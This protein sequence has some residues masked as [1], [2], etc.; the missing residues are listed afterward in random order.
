MRSNRL[1][2]GT[3][4]L[5]L[6]PFLAA[7]VSDR[8]EAPFTFVDIRETAG[9][10]FFHNSSPDKK[11]I[12]ES[13]A[14]GVALFDYNNDG[15]LDIYFVNSLTVDTA[16]RPESSRSHLYRNNGD[17]TFTD[18]TDEAGIGF[19]GWG[20]GV[21]V[22]DYDNDGW[23]DVYV[24]CLG[25]NRLFRNNGDGTFTEVGKD[26]GVDDD[27]WSSGCGFADFNGTGRLDLY[28]ANYVD[29]KLDDL[30][31]FGKGAFCQYRGIPVQCGPRGLPGAGNALFRND[32]DRFVDVSTEAGVH[33]P[34]G[35]YGLGVIWTDLNRNGFPDLFVANDARPN[36]LFENNGDGTFTELGFISGTAVGE[37][38]SEQGCMGVAIGDYDRDGDLDIFI[39]NF[40][41]EYNVLYR[42]ERS[43]VFTD[44]SFA[45]RTAESSF[46]F[47]GWGTEFVDFNNNGWLDLFVA[48]GHVYPQVDNV[49]LGT[50]YA[51]RKLLY[52]NNGDGTFTEAA[53]RHGDAL[54]QP[55]VSRGAAFG[56]LDNDGDIDIVLNDLDGFP[57]ILR[58]DGGNR[59]NWLRVRLEGDGPNRFGLGAWVTVQTGD[60][61][62]VAEVRSG[63][64]YLSQNDLRQHFG[65]G[66]ATMVDR[67]EVR[68]P[69]G[70]VTVR[71][72]VEINRELIVQPD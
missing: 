51:Q 61:V 68:W 8:D 37:D 31:E 29:F 50:S 5:L 28:V 59:K 58:N 15:L 47:V 1:L 7:P 42:Q 71:E 60:F 14:G 49:N 70:K 23:L 55:K 44:V 38:G 18:V 9:I 41:D 19:P 45:S 63:S 11:Y 25:P 10:R 69:D 54:M 36:L 56:D 3:L 12:V 53:A 64:S 30:P 4:L 33:D 34:D 26:L 35:N 32:G 48:N 52:R 66:D 22:G 27:R 43:L 2:P 21:C 13:M 39:S 72:N 62:Q 40:S 65:L 16:N 67:V 57:T 20:M 17:G 46:P 24:T 6:S